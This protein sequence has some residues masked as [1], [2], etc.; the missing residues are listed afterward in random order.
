MPSSEYMRAYRKSEGGRVAI[1]KQK[2]RD[3]AKQRALATLKLRYKAEF[4]T[5]FRM[6]LDAIE[7]EEQDREDV[8]LSGDVRGV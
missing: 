6:H 5:L 2:L 3:K 4:D 1:R 7:R 8:D